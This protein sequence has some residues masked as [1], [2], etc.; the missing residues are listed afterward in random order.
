LFF[1][2][3]IEIGY[4]FNSPQFWAIDGGYT[5][6][7]E[8]AQRFSED[9]ADKLIESNCKLVGK[10]DK[11]K[12]IPKFAKWRCEDVEKCAKLTVDIQDLAQYRI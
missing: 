3:N 10:G 8:Q 5:Q 11:L 7:I 4:A 9:A 12:R 1:L 2:Q 6:W